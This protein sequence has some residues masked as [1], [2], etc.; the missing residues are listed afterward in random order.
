MLRLNF[1]VSEDGVAGVG[2]LEGMKK[3]GAEHIVAYKKAVAEKRVSIKQFPPTE[4]RRKRGVLG[5]G[6]AATSGQANLQ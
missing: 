3:E 2:G 4:G 1:G 6:A 5:R